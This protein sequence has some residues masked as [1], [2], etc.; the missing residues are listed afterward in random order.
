[1]IGQEINNLKDS[2]CTPQLPLG[3][4]DKANNTFCG[5]SET[6]TFSTLSFA[7]NSLL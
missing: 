1:M 4:K 7:S 6:V 5:V 3:V 2:F